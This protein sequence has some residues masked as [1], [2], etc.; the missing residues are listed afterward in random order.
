MVLNRSHLVG[1]SDIN[2]QE[3]ANDEAAIMQGIV[4]VWDLDETLTFNSIFPDCRINEMSCTTIFKNEIADS[5]IKKLIKWFDKNPL[6][7]NVVITNNGYNHCV[8]DLKEFIIS[9]G[10]EHNI[11]FIN[12]LNYK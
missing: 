8:H 3:R 9:Q 11:S 2:L 6:H 10:K 1:I 5:W 12:N 7:S 4:L